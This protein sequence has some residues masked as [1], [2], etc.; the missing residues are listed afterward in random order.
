MSTY[1]LPAVTALNNAGIV[2]IVARGNLI[3]K[4]VD[5]AECTRRNF[6]NMEAKIITGTEVMEK[7]E[8]DKVIKRNVST[9]EITID[10]GRK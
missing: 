7:N 6:P 9:I 8:N 1:V 4:A 10:D 3:S 5:V 2:K